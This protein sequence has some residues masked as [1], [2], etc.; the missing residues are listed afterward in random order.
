MCELAHAIKL[1]LEMDGVLNSYK[2]GD[3]DKIETYTGVA[4]VRKDL[5]VL[6]KKF[7]SDAWR[8]ICILRHATKAKLANIWLA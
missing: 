6:Q 5:E 2:L 4:K 3:K 8:S 7:R 1:L